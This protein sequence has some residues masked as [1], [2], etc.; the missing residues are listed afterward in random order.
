[1][2][3]QT[4]A[5]LIEDARVVIYDHN[6]FTIQATSV[7]FFLVVKALLRKGFLLFLLDA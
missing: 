2:M 4:V 6:M 7:D 1:M 3:L 5:S